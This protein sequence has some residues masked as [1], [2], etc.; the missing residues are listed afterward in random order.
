MDR[1]P[2]GG[3]FERY[4]GLRVG[5]LAEHS[6]YSALELTRALSAQ[7]PALR[8]R[9][10]TAASARQLHRGHDAAAPMLWA[11]DF[12]LRPGLS[13]ELAAVRSAL[14]SVAEEVLVAAPE[15]FLGA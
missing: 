4:P 6:E 9:L 3:V 7:D 13:G 1:R 5:F 14:G 15:R 11:S 2:P 12:P 8:S 10:F